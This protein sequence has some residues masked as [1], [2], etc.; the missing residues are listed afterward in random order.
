V[1][2]SRPVF[3]IVL[4]K[5]GDPNIQTRYVP[6]SPRGSRATSGII[7]ELPLFHIP[8]R[9]GSAYGPSSF[10][11]RTSP[12][13]QSSSLSILNPPKEPASKV[14]CRSSGSEHLTSHCHLHTKWT[15]MAVY[16]IFPL[17]LSNATLFISAD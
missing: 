15:E 9:V 2:R 11:R 13:F 17:H 8:L 4:C 3:R 16:R 14:A 6:V 5:T 1:Q 10:K 7:K 12:T